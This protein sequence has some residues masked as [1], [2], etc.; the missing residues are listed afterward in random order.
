ML[1]GCQDVVHVE[2]TNIPEKPQEMIS[3]F[4]LDPLLAIHT[5][6]IIWDTRQVV[7][8]LGKNAQIDREN[9]QKSDLILS[10]TAKEQ[11]LYSRDLVSFQWIYTHIPV[12]NPKN[13]LKTLPELKDQINRI[14]DAL[15]TA[16]RDNRGTYYDNAWNY[17]YMLENLFERFSS[18]IKEY[19]YT[20]F[21][22]IGRSYSNFLE[23]YDLGKYHIA[24]YE[25]L[26]GFLADKK[27]EDRKNANIIKTIF[28]PAI[29][30]T[31]RENI[32]KKYNVVVYPLAPLTEDT[33]AWWYLRYVEKIMNSFANAFDTYD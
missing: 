3:I 10:T 27:W 30:S 15:I 31:V 20:P 25:T 24:H 28:T 5:K 1:A 7:I 26:E 2:T 4:T 22:T 11:Y 9:I 23:L 6:M 33:S 12:E 19:N 21:I 29:T 17:I 16:D 32:E 13:V 8:G 18:R 14:I